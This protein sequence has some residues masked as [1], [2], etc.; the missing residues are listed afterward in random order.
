MQTAARPSWRRADTYL[1][2]LFG[3]GLDG[4]DREF[5]V[6]RFR[7]AYDGEIRPVDDGKANGGRGQKRRILSLRTVRNLRPARDEIIIA[8]SV[9]RDAGIQLFGS[10]AAGIVLR[11]KWRC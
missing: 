10:T 3:G 8:T 4:G 9:N 5:V 7:S 1:T 6:E 2:H 11:G